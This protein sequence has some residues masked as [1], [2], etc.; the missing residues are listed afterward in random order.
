M[1]KMLF[2][3]LVFSVVALGS[4]VAN[5]ANAVANAKPK[6]VYISVNVPPVGFHSGN[7]HSCPPPVHNYNCKHCKR[8]NHNCC[9]PK[10]HCNHSHNHNYGKGKPHGNHGFKPHGKP[11]GVNHGR[12]N[13]APG[14]GHGGRPGGSYS[15]APGRR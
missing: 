5:D 2:L 12:H 8:S 7:H 3:S 15:H 1:K 9:A 6:N 4:A 14:R 11:G 13:G 10:H